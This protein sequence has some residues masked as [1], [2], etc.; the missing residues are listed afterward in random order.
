MLIGGLVAQ[1]S[2]VPNTTDTVGT[3]SAGYANA[4]DTVTLFLTILS[5]TVP[6]IAGGL[7]LFLRNTLHSSIAHDIR[8]SECI[9]LI[10]Q[11]LEFYRASRFDDVDSLQKTILLRSAIAITKY[12]MTVTTKMDIDH[13]LTRPL[14]ALIATNTA[15]FCMDLADINPENAAL[16]SAMKDQALDF[17]DQ[18]DLAIDALKRNK[19]DE[20]GICW[21]MIYESSLNVRYRCADSEEAKKET[22]KEMLALLKAKKSARKWTAKISDDWKEMGASELEATP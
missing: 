5:I 16:R 12:A 15:Y 4:L 20:E 8:E 2:T 22:T 13:R 7:Y 10:Y 18:E 14:K 6:I 9:S 19:L 3:F 17:L 11:G 21:Y 1:T